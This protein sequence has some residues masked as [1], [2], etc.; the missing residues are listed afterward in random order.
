MKKPKDN[1]EAIENWYET[2]KDKAEKKLHKDI[3]KGID[4]KSREET[5]LKELKSLRE[6]Y[7]NLHDRR[8]RF[9][10]FK[11]KHID[12]ILRR[13]EPFFLACSKTRTSIKDIIL[14]LRISIRNLLDSLLLPLRKFSSIQ[15]L[16]LTYF[17]KIMDFFFFITFKLPYKL[18][19]GSF[20]SFWNLLTKPRSKEKKKSTSL[21]AFEKIISKPISEFMSEDFLS[22]DEFEN[23]NKILRAF[24]QKEANVAVLMRHG[25]FHGCISSYSIV[26]NFDVEKMDKNRVWANQFREQNIS[27]VKYD[28][29]FLEAFETFLQKR[30]WFIFVLKKNK[31]VGVVYPKD[32]LFALEDFYRTVP[33][34]VLNKYPIEEYM[35]TK[36]IDIQQNEKLGIVQNKISLTT[37]K[38]NLILH[39][40]SPIGIIANLDI[41]REISNRGKGVSGSTSSD[42]MSFPVIT[43]DFNL[44]VFEVMRMMQNTNLKK[45]VVVDKGIFR[46]VVS[47]LNVLQVTKSIVEDIEKG[48]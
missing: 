13:L 46:G 20:F 9:L 24:V 21:E 4:E 14:T 34:E 18:F 32:I 6:K 42:I 12:P 10:L 48:D 40:N 35:E 26:N 28:D 7:Q 23:L 22:F 8:H 1:D 17:V 31:V 25:I 29:T 30:C 44:S 43:L 33:Q 41:I 38:A 47:V 3:K 2:K 37:E 27:F 11:I 36:F 15:D 5:Y 16:I 45:L 19:Y 39:K